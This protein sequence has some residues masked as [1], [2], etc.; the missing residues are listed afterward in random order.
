MKTR[1]SKNIRTGQMD[2]AAREI[3]RIWEGLEV[4]DAKKD[5]R[6]VVLPCDVQDATRKDPASC[7]FA[8]ACRR[9]LGSTKV[10]IFRSIAYADIPDKHGVR[11]VERFRLTRGM[12]ELIEAFDRGEGVLPEGGFLLKA[13]TESYTLDFKR[14]KKL[15]QAIRRRADQQIVGESVTDESA[16]QGQQGIGKYRDRPI[17]LDLVRS[18]TGAVHFP[19]KKKST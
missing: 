11:R 15:Q 16:C 3:H 18:G 1:K 5:I 19:Y 2:R 9:V 10:L 14:V 12:R 6:L 17:I 8:R 4:L 7:V 13:P